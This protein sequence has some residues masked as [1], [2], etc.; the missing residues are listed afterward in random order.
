ESCNVAGMEGQCAAIPEPCGD[1][2]G[3]CDC[4]G[5]V[6]VN[7]LVLMVDIAL[8]DTG[9]SRCVAGDPNRD[10]QITIDEL[11]SAVNNALFECP[12]SS[13]PT[14]T[15][16]PGTGGGTSRRAGGTTIGLAQGL[17]ALPLLFSSIT[18]LAS[19]AGLL[20][21]DGEGGA[22]GLTAC[23][24]GGT[25][26]FT[27]TQALPGASPRDY[28]LTFNDCVLN[29]A[30]GGTVALDGTITGQS[31]DT[32]PLA[33]C[34]VP[35]LAL[36][37]ASISNVQVVTKNSAMVTTLTATFNLTGSVTVTP[38]LFASCR[39]SGFTTMLNGTMAVQSAAVSSTAT[40]QN[41]GVV[42][43]IDQFST[44]CVPVV[45]QLTLNGG[46][47]FDV[48]GV[49]NPLSATFSNFEFGDNTTSGN[50][51]ITMNG[52]LSSDCL[53]AGVVFDTQTP[54]TIPPGMLC[55]TSGA[56]LVTVGQ[57]TD[58]LNY[59]AG[60]GVAIDLG[61]NATIDDTLNTCLDPQLFMCVGG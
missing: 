49:G 61:N 14:P 13:T 7:E 43:H 32:G 44:S 51:V 37:T 59:T 22:A 24:V 26:D 41:T 55:P 31:T 34:G 8:R 1:C 18:Q 50:D 19:G 46:A 9:T 20:T 25:R 54:L 57:T 58:R 30:G 5:V 3:D 36:S 6:V 12:T 48:S 10:D 29:T 17:R 33:N 56:V 40:F 42:L 52:Q 15:A 4:N 27:C 16:T 38:D 28:T 21:T 2:I 23:S 11:V 60:G 45:F 39:I 47:T 35:P 53:G